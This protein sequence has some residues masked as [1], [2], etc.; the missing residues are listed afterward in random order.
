MIGIK[1]PDNIAIGILTVL[2]FI[3][4]ATGAK[5]SEES[6]E[7]LYQNFGGSLSTLWFAGDRLGVET[8]LREILALASTKGLNTPNEGD[9]IMVESDNQASY[10]DPKPNPDLKAL[11]RLI[12]RWK[13]SGDAQGEVSYQWM[14]GGFFMLQ[15]FDIQHG[16]RRN[17]GIEV[18]GHLKGFA[19]EPGKEIRT[20]VYNFLDG[21]TLDY[22]YEVE[23]DSLTIWGG[24]K[25]SSAYYKGRF[26]PDGNTLTGR[27]VYPG[28]GY[29]T[30]STRI[31]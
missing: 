21:L 8:P 15:H 5:W 11:D 26:S 4:L 28:G 10:E 3:V 19:E 23:G 29:G 7:A 22:V 20:R 17:K 12:G 14:E 31:K 1:R 2:P 18:I 9:A 24:E 6:S 16:K 13:I 27:W 25:G 30:T